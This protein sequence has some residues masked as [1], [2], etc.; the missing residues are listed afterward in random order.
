MKTIAFAKVLPDVYKP[1]KPNRIPP[2]NIRPPS[3][4]LE[5]NLIENNESTQE[6][7]IERLNELS[8]EARWEAEIIR[9]S[10]DYARELRVKGFPHH[11]AFVE[12]Q[13]GDQA[14]MWLNTWQ[15]AL[16]TYSSRTTDFN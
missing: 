10:F 3:Y 5:M 16:Y 4:Q 12:N 11:A 6:S 8:E 9:E 2:A 15:P 1:G 14:R 13:A 7:M